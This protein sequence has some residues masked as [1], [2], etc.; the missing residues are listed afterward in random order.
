MSYQQ[1]KDKLYH[2]HRKIANNT[3][4]TL[5]P[6][7]R[8][9]DAVTGYYEEVSGYI[10]MRLHGHVIAKFYP[11]RLEL[12]SAGWHTRTT[13]NRLNLALELAGLRSYIYQRN[14]HWYYHSHY[15]GVGIEFKEGIKINYGGTVTG[16]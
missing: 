10:Q 16:G 9:E 6:G 4:L 2:G 13:K 7:N 12:Y 11:D 5:E 15:Y 3:Y 8:E 14:Y 1:V